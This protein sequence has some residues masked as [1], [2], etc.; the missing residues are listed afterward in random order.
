MGD[1]VAFLENIA[2][3]LGVAL[4]SARLYAQTRQRAEQERMVDELTERMRATLDIQTVLE[5]AARELR[6]ALG[7][8]EV[9]V[10]LGEAR[11]NGSEIETTDADDLRRGNGVQ[12]HDED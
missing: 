4:D 3:Q 1:E 8:A 10:R 2:E 9:E 6:S 5:T 11:T 12:R 7:L